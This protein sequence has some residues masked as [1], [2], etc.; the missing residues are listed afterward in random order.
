MSI[1]KNRLLL[2]IAL[3]ALI[4]LGCSVLCQAQADARDFALQVYPSPIVNTVNPGES[5]TIELK[6]RNNGSQKENLKIQTRSFT[7]DNKNEQVKL[8]NI[9]PIDIKNWIIFSNPTFSLDT[10]EWF[11]QRITIKTPKNAGFSYPFVVL[12]SRQDE[13]KS[14]KGATAI[15]G[16]VA[17]FTLINVN[18]PDAKK[19]LELVSFSSQKRVY[20]Y[21]PATFKVKINNSGNTIVLPYGN[22]FIQ[23][24]KNA[25]APISVEALNQSKSYILPGTART[26]TVEWNYGF[27]YYAN[28]QSLKTKKLVWDWGK[29]RDFRVGRYTAVLVGAYNDGHRDL[30]MQ[31][32]LTFW[33]FPWK[34]FLIGLVAL[35]IFVIGIYTI[36]K[37]SFQIIPKHGKNNVET[38][39]N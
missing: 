5:K 7:Y 16:S 25:K 10:G 4:L 28:Q 14:T 9:E 24:S 27:P 18:R 26:L 17:V 22:V 37:K 12:I 21:L 19:Q 1:V 20:E 35:T 36:I 13:A 29:L 6:I 39:Q 33:V 32:S 31:A 34:L 11:T 15:Q 2:A 8:D 23:R 3:F 30:P 38:N